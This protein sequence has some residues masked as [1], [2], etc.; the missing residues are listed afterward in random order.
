MTVPAATPFNSYVLL[1]CA[2]NT[3]TVVETNES[4]NCVASPTAVV[5]VARPDLVESTVSNPPASRARGT[6]FQV[7][8]TVQ[9]LGALPSGSTNTRYY[10]SLDAV[11]G[12]GDTAVTGSRSVP[13]VAAGGSHSGTVTVTI[14]SATPLNTYFL[15]ACADNGNTVV[16]TDE[17]NNCKASSTMLTVTP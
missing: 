16:E 6:T 2:D 7:T 3:N 5:T 4:N 12:S 15:L 10:L 11:K 13:A 14:P 9:N 17:T 8:D 1:A